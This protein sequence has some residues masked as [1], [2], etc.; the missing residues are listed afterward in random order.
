MTIQLSTVDEIEAQLR[1]LT[2]G[3]V[4]DVATGGGWFLAWML[5]T[6][7]DT[8]GGVGLDMR[9]LDGATS[10]DDS[11]FNRANVDYVQGDAAHMDFPAA[12]FDTVVMSASIHHMADPA[13]VLAEMRRVLKPGGSLIIAEMYRDHQEGPSETHV[14]MHH[15]WAAVDSALGIVHNETYPREALIAMLNALGLAEMAFY[16]TNFAAGS[17]PFDAEQRTTLL[18]RIDHYL[19]RA[20]DLP[21]Y[22]ELGA[23]AADI[24]HRLDTQG[25]RPANVLI[26]IGRK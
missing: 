23:R 15:W 4:L 10:D 1:T 26:A 3:R 17:D 24:R 13:P 14:A 5:D 12:S 19:T 25:F 9:A 22:A 21:N 6:L 11:L 20:E 18:S 8:T 7:Q 16:D 2:G